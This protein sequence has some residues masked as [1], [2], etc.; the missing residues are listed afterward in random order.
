MRTFIAIEVPSEIKSVLAA[1]QNDLKD[2]GADIA[3]THP[4]N[5][6]LTLKF[7]GEIDKK[8]S[9][10]V[11]KI[12]VDAGR[13]SS[14]FTLTINGM[15]VFPTARHP[16]VLWI[17]LAGEIKKLERLQEDLDERL[18]AFG[19]DPEEKDFRPHLTLGRVKSNRNIREL[20][21]KAG[22]YSL[23]KLSFSV[24]ELILMKSDLHPTGAC[25]T[26]LARAR[27][28]GD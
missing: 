3:W 15:G 13:E 1:M 22:H 14:I 20:I 26:E 6:H 21:E 11:E 4:E 12:C 17:G 25:Y 10:A 23:P 16:R 9:S 8:V 5:I 28:S 19:F 2:V 24:R 18:T 27:L 7:L